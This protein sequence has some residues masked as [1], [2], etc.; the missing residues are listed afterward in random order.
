[1]KKIFNLSAGFALGGI[2]LFFTF[3]GKNMADVWHSIAAADL[4]LSVASLFLMLLVFVLRAARWQLLLREAGTP[5][6]FYD[7]LSSLGMGY[8]VNCITPKFG[9]VARCLSLQRNADIPL[10]NSL[11]TV[12]S[13]RVYDIAVLALGLA[14]IFAAEM[15]RLSSLASLISQQTTAL[16]GAHAIWYGFLSFVT[17]VSFIIIFRKQIGRIGVFSR[18]S[19]FFRQVGQSVAQSFSLTR[20]WLFIGYT[21]GIWLTLILVNYVFLHAMN[22]AGADMHFAVIVLFISSIGWALPAPGGVGTSHFIV[23]QLFLAFGKSEESGLAFGVYSNGITLAFILA[24]GAI[25]VAD[26]FWG[27]A[28]R[29]KLRAQGF[30]R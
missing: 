7:V 18:A 8:F 17:V 11:G 25:A 5:V 29:S 3:R 14:L 1:M 19:H 12:I 4:L 27:R 10:A 28:W 13:E 21:I 23:L 9:E 30:S 24:F 16:F 2:L 20:Y 15:T 26:Y 22:I 6:A